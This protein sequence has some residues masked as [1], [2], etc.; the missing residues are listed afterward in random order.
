M[1][2][3]LVVSVALLLFASG[4]WANLDGGSLSRNTGAWVSHNTK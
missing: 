4:V 1:T 3:V 2:Q